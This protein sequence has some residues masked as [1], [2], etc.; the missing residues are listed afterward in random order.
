MLLERPGELVS[1][2]EL[3]KKL[4]PEDT[5]VDFEHSINA[6]VK[7][8][9]E[10]LGDDA[11][12]PRFV[13]T[14][15]RRGYRFI[16]SADVGAGLVSAHEGR[17]QGAPLRR[18][19]IVLAGAIIVATLA[20]L[21]A[22][23]V[24]DLRDRLL[25]HAS[26]PPKIESIAVLPLEN[27]S[28]D[29]DQEYFADGM[30][31]ELITNLGKISALRVISRTSV[32]H[33][34]GT[35]K[36]LP[37]IARELN[38]DAIVEGTVLRSGNRI[39]ITAQLLHAPTD[40]HL[41]AESYD[42]DLGDVLKLQAEVA[43]SITQEVNIKLTPQDRTRLEI[44]RPVNP[45]AYQS[46]LL[47]LYFMNK[48]DYSK[49]LEPLQRAINIDPKYAPAYAAIADW[50][51]PGG[52]A[53]MDGWRKAKRLATKA[54]ELDESVAE[55]HAVLG[56]LAY[57][58]EWDWSVAEKE[59]R[60]AVDLNPSSSAAHTD[61]GIY[62]ILVGRFEEGNAEAERALQLDPFSVRTS[63]YAGWIFLCG[64]HYDRAI[65][66]HRRTLEMDPEHWLS[67]EQLAAA[68]TWSGRQPEAIAAAEKFAEREG[69]FPCVGIYAYAVSGRRKEAQK[70]L[71][72]SIR[73]GVDPVYLAAIEVGLD[74]KD[75]AFKWLERAYADRSWFCIFLKAWPMFDPLRSDPRFQDLV[76]RMNFPP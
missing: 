62:L 55:A 20:A 10:A 19:Y 70:F 12:N 71:A 48:G 4:W 67:Y 52:Y 72:D 66:Q 14:L 26:P 65:A 69:H 11:D 31:D 63:Q 34:K 59:L 51:S 45:Q 42:R 17:P 30:T 24:A 13:E 64:R 56:R 61:Y 68:Y 47:G 57:S 29:P 53:G 32:M 28:R 21:L 1:R 37:E 39:R 41:W 54:V 38:V 50:Y 6:A 36:T 58:L 74:N 33:F 7:R 75:D 5:F 3:Q 15:P 18:R 43:R 35:K 23:N 8:L 27:L 22:F 25:R 2:E 40:R 44:A 49:A 60:R 16:A 46:C 9:R 73:R 76:R